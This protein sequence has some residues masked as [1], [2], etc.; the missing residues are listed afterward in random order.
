MSPT[1]R[2]VG[3]QYTTGAEQRSSSRKNEEVEPKWRQCPVV[4]VSAGES[5]KKKV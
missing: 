1:P 3:I 2:L 4:D 5:K